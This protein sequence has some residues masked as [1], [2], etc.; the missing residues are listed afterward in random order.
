MSNSYFVAGKRIA[1]IC[2]A[3]FAERSVNAKKAEALAKKHFGSPARA[4]CRRTFEG[5]F[6]PVGFVF[7]K[8]P[9]TNAEHLKCHRVYTSVQCPRAST[10]FGKQLK[11]QLESLATTHY[12]K[13][14]QAIGYDVVR[15]GA[16]GFSTRMPGIEKLGGKFVL[17]VPG[18]TELPGC[19]RISDLAYERMAAK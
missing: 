9:T 12:C 13:L 11:A 5:D 7:T 14:M 2:A 15:Y 4:A 19:R 1:D 18:V 6:E 17:T 10:K 16:E 3:F 8:E